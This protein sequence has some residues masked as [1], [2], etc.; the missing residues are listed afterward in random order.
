I[1]AYYYPYFI[2]VKIDHL[3]FEES[4]P[5]YPT[6]EDA[7]AF[8]DVGEIIVDRVFEGGEDKFRMVGVS[9]TNPDTKSYP[10]Y[11]LNEINRFMFLESR[12]YNPISV[13]VDYWS[14]NKMDDSHYFKLINSIV[15]KVERY[16]HDTYEIDIS[17]FVILFPGL[18]AHVE[19]FI[20][21]TCVLIDKILKSYDAAI[22]TINAK[23]ITTQKMIMSLMQA[24]K[25]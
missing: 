19:K 8:L 25:K 17:D 6:I 2:K 14:I 3:E 9:R 16:G 10:F 23:N 5:K 1:P 12:D 15:K 20:D 11:F 24:K 4:N 21:D 7:L 18:I 13:I 22:S